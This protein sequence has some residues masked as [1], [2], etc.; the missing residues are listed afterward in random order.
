MIVEDQYITVHK[1]LKLGNIE[2][3]E[4]FHEKHCKNKKS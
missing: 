1:I 2:H 4:H 3:T